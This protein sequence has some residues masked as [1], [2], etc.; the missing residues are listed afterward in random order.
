VEFT[1]APN[2]APGEGLPHHEW[3]IEFSKA[4]GDLEEFALELD[5][6]L[7]EA[8]V[9][10]DDLISGSILRTL[11]I[12]A[13][14]KNAFIDYMKSR[15]KLGGQNKVPRLANDRRI[16]EELRKWKV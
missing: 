8:N 2:V 16:A 1:V 6:R 4:P 14:K 5:H 15:G 9:Y 10:Y 3:L 12:T 7:R 11:K 13:L